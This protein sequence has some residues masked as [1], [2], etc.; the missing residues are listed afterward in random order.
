M[1][2]FDRNTDQPPE[3]TSVEQELKRA[4]F[5]GWRDV[6]VCL[7]IVGVFLL[8]QNTEFGQNLSKN[9]LGVGSY[10]GLAPVLEEKQF[11]ITGLDGVTHTFVY[12]DSDIE[13]CSGLKDYLA[14]DKGEMLEGSETKRVCSGLYR[15]DAF[16]DYQLHVQTKLDSYM[17]V[18]T[19]DGVIV[20]NLESNDTTKELYN[21][22]MQLREDQL[23]KA[24]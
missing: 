16:G 2:F 9:V 21:Y 18:R 4:R 6:I 17:V 24:S 10:D 22:F 20:F 15:N 7:V 19:A 12:V 13:L 5:F 3:G 23:A 8:I 11:G 14:K 1:G